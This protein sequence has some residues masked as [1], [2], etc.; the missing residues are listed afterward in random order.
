MILKNKAFKILAVLL[1]AA[2]VNHASSL[3]A[4][5][6]QDSTGSSQSKD[7][8]ENSAMGVDKEIDD[9]SGDDKSDE[10]TE[11][12]KFQ[13]DMDDAYTDASADKND[14]YQSKFKADDGDVDKDSDVSDQDSGKD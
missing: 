9:G 1:L 8:W 6:N 3:W 14:G 11:E 2:A 13:K 7:S 12:S 5:G 4:E 10:S